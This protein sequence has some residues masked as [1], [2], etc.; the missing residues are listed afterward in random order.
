MLV[1]LSGLGLLFCFSLLQREGKVVNCI[2]DAFLNEWQ[3]FFCFV[4]AI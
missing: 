4:P 2:V 3:Q 1:G